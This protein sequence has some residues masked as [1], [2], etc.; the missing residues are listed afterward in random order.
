MQAWDVFGVVVRTLGLLLLLYA[1]TLF[2]IVAIRLLGLQVESRQT[3]AVDAVLLV[4]YSAAGLA[5]LFG[6]PRIVRA[7]YA[8]DS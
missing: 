2:T 1:L 6:A 5:M 7:L 3:L 8:G 4:I